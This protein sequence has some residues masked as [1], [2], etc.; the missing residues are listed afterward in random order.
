[1]GES[2]RVGHFA[3]IA[4]GVG[5]F[6]LIAL[7]FV[8]LHYFAPAQLSQ[9]QNSDDAERVATFSTEGELVLGDDRG[10]ILAALQVRDLD[11]AAT[12]IADKGC[13]F[14][15]DRVDA[16]H[17]VN[18]VGTPSQ[19]IRP[20][21]PGNWGIDIACA[22]QDRGAILGTFL[23]DGIAISRVDENGNPIW[24]Q[25]KNSSDLN[26]ET[27]SMMQRD[28]T[29]FVISQETA[30]GQV[31]VISIDEN[32]DENWEL[33]IATSGAIA[34]PR[35][36]G[37]SFGEIQFAWNEGENAVRLVTLSASG[38]AVQDTMMESQALPLRAISNDDIARTLVLQG[39]GQ[40]FAE[41][42][43]ASGT[44]E[45]QWQTDE[46]APIGVLR[47]EQDFLVL[48]TS[49]SGLLAWKLGAS[50]DV[51]NRLEVD[52]VDDVLS[53]GVRRLNA[54][55]AV[56]TLN[57]ADGATI[58]LVL[59]LRRLSDGLPIESTN[60]APIDLVTTDLAIAAD[61][62]ASSDPVTI[63]PRSGVDSS[64]SDLDTA[65]TEGVATS[66]AGPELDSLTLEREPVTAPSVQFPSVE[67]NSTP[68]EPSDALSGQE[69][70][71]NALEA[72]GEVPPTEAEQAPSLAR[73]TFTC[74]ALDASAAE[75]TL[76]QTVDVGEGET[77]A[78]VALRLNDTHE[79]LCSVSGGRPVEDYTR[80]CGS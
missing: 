66:S 13:Q 20:D 37:N 25:V 70:S 73:C 24:T 40:V 39:D 55:E 53:G 29:L 71:S 30:S 17:W 31:K 50:G 65:P 63:D 3:R 11:G 47:H 45:W 9:Q 78:D 28:E 79:T 1:M 38:I 22:T 4:I 34:R 52:L 36:L 76:M 15:S 41:L 58:D 19:R 54:A 7:F 6:A 60:P 33:P 68:L 32:G 62:P 23:E 46:A 35:V 49:G 74:V 59:D 75:Y 26:P 21:L 61:I 72:N 64:G 14:L 80:Q 18:I 10:V 77:F 2:R 8:G 51:S 56:A 42:V 67:D 48:A 5:A 57:L 43:S 12:L 44:T 27:V 69:N 16:I